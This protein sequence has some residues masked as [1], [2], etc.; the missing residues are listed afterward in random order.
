MILVFSCWAHQL[1]EHRCDK[2]FGSAVWN[3]RCVEE[4][5]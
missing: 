4:F 1:P 3:V 2:N 5:M